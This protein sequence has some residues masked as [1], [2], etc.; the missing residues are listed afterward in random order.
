MKDINN[1]PLVVGDVVILLDCPEAKKY[2]F[3][4][5]VIEE[6]RLIG[7]RTRTKIKGAFSGKSIIFASNKLKKIDVLEIGLEV[8]AYE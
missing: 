4:F 5:W 3:E 7:T 1:Q 2:P 8:V 6:E